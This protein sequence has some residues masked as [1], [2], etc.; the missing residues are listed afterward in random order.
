MYPFK[1]GELIELLN[2]SGFKKISMYSNFN[3][4]YDKNAEF[5]TYV[6]SK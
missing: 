1:K 2:E 4:G 6:A 5:Y 3:F